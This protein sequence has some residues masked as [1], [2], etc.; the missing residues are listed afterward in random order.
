[1]IA[2]IIELLATMLWLLSKETNQKAWEKA[3]K[4]HQIRWNR[5]IEFADDLYCDETYEEE[6][7]LPPVGQPYW[8]WVIQYRRK[9]YILG[10]LVDYA[11]C[12]LCNPLLSI[13]M[14]YIWRKEGRYMAEYEDYGETD[15]DVIGTEF[16][17]CEIEDDW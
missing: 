12:E 4:Y 7:G 5:L 11:R 10:T 16:D 1:M 15:C 13:Q 9:Q 3:R 14:K 17:E 6:T 8:D 2:I